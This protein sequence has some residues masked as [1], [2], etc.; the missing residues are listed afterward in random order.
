M[1]VQNRRPYSRDEGKMVRA[2]T[3]DRSSKKREDHVTCREFDLSLWTQSPLGYVVHFWEPGTWKISSPQNWSINS[4]TPSTLHE[5][6]MWNTKNNNHKTMTV[7]LNEQPP[8]LSV[9][10][11]VD[12]CIWLDCT[13]F[14]IFVLFCLT[15][16]KNLLS[17]SVRAIS[18]SQ[19]KINWN[20]PVL[21][22]GMLKCK[23]WQNNKELK[24]KHSLT[25]LIQI[26]PNHQSYTCENPP[27]TRKSHIFSSQIPDL[28]QISGLFSSKI[29]H[30][31]LTLIFSHRTSLI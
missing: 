17:L 8:A 10:L 9:S 23:E 26:P 19:R 1:T 24:M 22:Q 5:V 2:F 12:L 30:F 29:Q 31:R 27:F 13:H 21:P 16:S 4:L 25:T 28:T 3:A 14:K 15:V 6:M 7:F 20:H 11:L 18:L